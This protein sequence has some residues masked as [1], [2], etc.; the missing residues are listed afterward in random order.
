MGG[1]NFILLIV[2]LYIFPDT[3]Y[4]QDM[5][6]SALPMF[7]LLKIPR[8][9]LAL[10]VLFCGAVSTDFLEPSMELHLK[11]FNLS[12]TLVGFVL[13]TSSVTYVIATPLFGYLCDKVPTS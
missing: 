5:N 7:P 3:A 13:V 1:L 4:N 6:K 11:P 9:I 12:S 10:L 8:F 2:G